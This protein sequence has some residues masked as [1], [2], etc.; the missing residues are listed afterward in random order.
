MRRMVKRGE[1]KYLLEFFY[2]RCEKEVNKKEEE[3][4]EV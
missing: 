1:K 2:D 3:E 4:E